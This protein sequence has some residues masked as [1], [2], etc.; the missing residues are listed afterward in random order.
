ML[1]RG[2]AAGCSLC[3]S[4]VAGGFKGIGEAQNTDRENR[5]AS[6]AYRIT[7]S[8]GRKFLSRFKTPELNIDGQAPGLPKNP[9][10]AASNGPSGHQSKRGYQA[11]GNQL[12]GVMAACGVLTA[13]S[14]EVS[15]RFLAECIKSRVGEW[16]AVIICGEKGAILDQAF[17]SVDLA[18]AVF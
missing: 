9:T 14:R 8:S 15:A 11:T 1:S 18:R 12:V 16:D 6:I 17:S 7:L 13:R 5:A 10:S 3:W 2:L 4:T